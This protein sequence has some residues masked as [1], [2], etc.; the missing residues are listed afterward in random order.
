MFQ[1]DQQYQP[2]IYLGWKYQFFK[3]IF[4]KAHEK[5]HENNFNQ[6]DQPSALVPASPPPGF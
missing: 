3:E 4:A 1:L 2:I 6:V 5:A